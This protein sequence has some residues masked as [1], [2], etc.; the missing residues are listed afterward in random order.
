MDGRNGNHRAA[1][2]LDDANPAGGIRCTSR[3]LGK[4]S[5]ISLSRVPSIHIRLDRGVIL[6]TENE[7]GRSWR[8]LLGNGDVTPEIVEKAE[9]LLDELRPESPLRHRLVTE[10]HELQKRADAAKQAAE[11]PK[12]KS[13]KKVAVKQ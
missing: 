8:L 7:V 12:A 4:E 5:A 13:R 10:L 2:K 6:L 3:R 1:L 11:K 9:A